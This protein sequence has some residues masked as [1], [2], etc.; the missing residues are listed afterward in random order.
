MAQ[1]YKDPQSYLDEAVSRRGK[2]GQL[3]VYLHNVTVVAECE[4][5]YNYKTPCE[6]FNAVTGGSGFIEEEWM[7]MLVT[8]RAQRV[9][10]QYTIFNDT[11]T[12]QFIPEGGKLSLNIFIPETFSHFF[13]NE[14]E[15]AQNI[16]RIVADFLGKVPTTIRFNIGVVWKS[17]EEMVEAGEAEEVELSY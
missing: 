1:T 2:S 15:T 17:W 9:E 14:V 11:Q 5:D 12:F 16:L 3:G 10:R 7:R 13:Q 4:T 8:L 6:E